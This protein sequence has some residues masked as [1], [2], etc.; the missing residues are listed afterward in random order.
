[1]ESSVIVLGLAVLGLLLGSFAGASVWRLRARQLVEDKADGEAVDAKEL[2][3]LRRIEKKS[4][5]EDRSVCLHCGHKLAWY[6]LVPVFSWL[7]LQ[8]K[9]RYCGRFIGWFELLIELGTATFFVVSYLSWPYGLTNVLDSILFGLWLVAGVGLIILLS[10]DSKWFLLPNR[11]MFP[12]IGLAAISASL[13]VI[14][15]PSPIETALSVMWACVILSGLYFVLYMV[16]RGE[17]I[18]FGDIKLGLALGLLLADWKLA[19]LALFMA[20]LI[21]TAIA[22][23]ALV[24]R[25]MGRNS[26]IPFGPMLILGWVL[27][28]LYGNAIIEWY[29]GIS[30]VL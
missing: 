4:I 8:G 30:L 18:G 3:R 20:N 2:K 11:V 17:W 25:K 14:A 5:S 23:P 21:G 12:V 19:L 26:R 9:C 13:H 1:M 7:Q 22:L 28:G 29:L 16:S 27:A 6:D 10:Y 24:T 15:S